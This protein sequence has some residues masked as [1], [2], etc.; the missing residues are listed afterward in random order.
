[1][2]ENIEDII[3]SEQKKKIKMKKMKKQKKKK[4]LSFNVN[5]YNL[6]FKKIKK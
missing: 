5:K 1:M 3:V 6:K 4:C 2:G